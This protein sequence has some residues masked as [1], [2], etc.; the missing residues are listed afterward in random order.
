[1]RI[2]DMPILI[3]QS[4]HGHPAAFQVHQ[5][6]YPIAVICVGAAAIIAVLWG[7]AEMLE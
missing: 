7:L 4:G 6:T 2:F 5:D 1:M 3:L